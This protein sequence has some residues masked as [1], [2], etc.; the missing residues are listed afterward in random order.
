M[1]GRRPLLM[2]LVLAATLHAV[3]MA[4]SLLP[5]QDGLKFIRIAKAFQT[6]PWEDVVRASDQHP[7]YPIL[8]AAVEPGLSLLMR[9]GPDTWRLAAQVVSAVASLLMV[10]VIHSLAKRLFCPTIAHLAAFGSVLLPL[11]MAV[12][13]DTLS[14]SLA[15]CAALT[16]LWLGVKALEERGVGSSI[17]CGVAAGVG[18]LARPEVLVVPLAVGLTGVLNAL[19]S[20]R[21]ASVSSSQ[22]AATPRLACLAVTFLALVGGYSLIKGEVSEKLALRQVAGLTRHRPRPMAAVN[23]RHWLPP[24]LDDP[25]WDFSPKEEAAPARPR[26]LRVLGDLGFQLAEGL[27][28]VLPLFVAWGF[29]RDR[30]IR[31]IIAS[32]ENP[33][34]PT[35]TGRLLL[36]VYLLLFL[37]IL[38]QHEY[39]MGYLSHR[40]VLTIVLVT[41]P[42][43]AAGVYVCAWR[44]AEV[45]QLGPA[46]RRA[47]SVALVATCLAVSAGVQLRGGHLSR[48]GHWAAGQWLAAHANPGESVLDT[49]GW[50]AFVSRLPSYDY[51]HVR[52]AFS[53]AGL[54]YVVVGDDELN[55]ASPRGQ[56][57]RAV[58]AYAGEPAASF[59]LE[60]HGQS[61]GV[62]VYTFHRPESWEGMR[63]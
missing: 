47:G 58:L 42:W 6:Q 54:S 26:P 1:S 15:L 36:A 63:P 28:W 11:L 18:Y 56:T 3:G 57:L 55:A 59:P 21:V 25:K 12:G 17:A 16:A 7:L 24:G 13:H 50:A 39:R 51:W 35:N 62:W 31:K 49:R 2:I 20:R 46:A 4:R 52:Q 14:D 9:H 48:W 10:V 61:A 37:L 8:V 45:L 44:F 33:P 22:T 34:D 38:A 27:G 60:R 29:A 43:A 30:Y 19:G 5:A 53:D 40:H 41:M 32:S 23:T